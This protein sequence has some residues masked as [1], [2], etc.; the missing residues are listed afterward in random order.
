MNAVRI[1]RK[2]SRY[3]SALSA[4][5]ATSGLVPKGTTAEKKGALS[6]Q[7]SLRLGVRRSICCPRTHIFSELWA[8]R[9]DVFEQSDKSL[10]SKRFR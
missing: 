2:L 5:A 10:E 3:D 1:N 9:V 8:V 4:L 6:Q 7:P